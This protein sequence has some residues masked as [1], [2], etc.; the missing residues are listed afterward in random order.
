MQVLL[1]HYIPLSKEILLI[2]KITSQ[3]AKIALKFLRKKFVYSKLKTSLRLACLFQSECQTII[4]MLIN[5][6]WIVQ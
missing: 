5:N 1:I 3:N 6:D 4:Q 2:P